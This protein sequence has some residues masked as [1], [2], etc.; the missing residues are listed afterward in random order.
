VTSAATP[1]ATVEV[2]RAA[3]RELAHKPCYAKVRRGLLVTDIIDVP[4]AAYR[5]LLDYEREAAERGY[6][7]LA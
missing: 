1:A 4:A 7:A 6:P 5:G 3:L 2:L